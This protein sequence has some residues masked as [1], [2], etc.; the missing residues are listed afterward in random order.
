MDSTGDTAFAFQRVLLD[1]ASLLVYD[2][3]FRWDSKWVKRA[4][5]TSENQIG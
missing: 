5:R 4:E 2:V 3:E 1:G